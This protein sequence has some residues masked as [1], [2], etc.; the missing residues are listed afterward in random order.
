MLTFLL[1]IDFW[2]GQH[3]KSASN[4]ANWSRSGCSFPESSLHHQMTSDLLSISAGSG[5]ASAHRPL[6]SCLFSIRS[7]VEFWKQCMYSV[8][9]V[10]IKVALQFSKLSQL[11]FF[12][13][14]PPV[15]WMIPRVIAAA[16]SLAVIKCVW[17]GERLVLTTETVCIWPAEERDSRTNLEA[18]LREAFH[19]CKGF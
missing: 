18:F 19:L 7:I 14:T 2:V 4:L 8:Q 6:A 11:V 12:N 10:I 16:K 17:P 5:L 3:G 13:M 9:S 1:A 15:T